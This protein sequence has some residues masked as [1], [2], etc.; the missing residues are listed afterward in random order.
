MI[1]LLEFDCD[2]FLM[3]E[4]W[5]GGCLRG[6]GFL[7]SKLMG[8][9]DVWS[10]MLSSSSSDSW[11]ASSSVNSPARRRNRSVVKYSWI[12]RCVGGW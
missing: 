7:G 12:F 5:V 1:R 10:G 2:F 8:L 3:G 6:V 11:F 4:G 9:L